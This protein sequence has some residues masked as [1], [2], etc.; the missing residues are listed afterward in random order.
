[1]VCLGSSGVETG[2]LFRDLVEKPVGVGDQGGLRKT[3]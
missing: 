1:M 2:E 3:I